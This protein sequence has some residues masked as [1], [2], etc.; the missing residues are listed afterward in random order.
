M[1][2]EIIENNV[3]IAKFM[4]FPYDDPEQFIVNDSEGERVGTVLDLKYHSSWDWLMPVVDR[5]SEVSTGKAH[6][7]WFDHDDI[8]IFREPIDDTY[9]EVAKFIKWWNE[10][11]Q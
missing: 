11:K 7:Y 4:E 5:I 1:E 6:L 2:K 10:N 9:R 8:R 3:L